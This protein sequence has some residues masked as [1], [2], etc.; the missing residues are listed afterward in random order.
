MKSSIK[1]PNKIEMLC[2]SDIWNIGSAVI[3]HNTTH[4]ISVIK[5]L[6]SIYIMLL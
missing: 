3:L 2:D 1:V 5:Q 4:K 6:V